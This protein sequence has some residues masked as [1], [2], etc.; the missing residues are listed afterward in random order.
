MSRIGKKTIQ[1]PPGVS[2]S[3]EN[4]TVTVS[5]PKGRLA[6]PVH[7]AVTILIQGTEVTV[8]VVNKEEKSERALW[9]TFGAHVTNMVEG[10]TNGFKKQL[11]I[12]G[13]GYRV[14]MQGK[15]LKLDVGFSHPVIFAI[16]EGITASVE[17]NVI[18]IVG[19]D[20]DQ[21]G[22]TSAQIRAVKKPEPYKGK[23]IKY[24]DEVIRRKAGKASKS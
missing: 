15:D 9:G 21:V 16:P 4:G 22:Q 6:R 24:T 8:D 18:T 2:V 20:K 10:V 11:E 14:A 19:I 3:F 5:G 1:T 23:G 7:P 17:K 13:V 12:N